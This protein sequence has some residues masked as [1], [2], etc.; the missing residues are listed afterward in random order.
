M[1]N[2]IYHPQKRIFYSVFSMEGQQV[3]NN[4]LL[5]GGSNKQ[6]LLKNADVYAPKAYFQG[7]NE[8]ETKK[9]LKRIKEGT[10]TSHKDPNAYRDFETDFRNGERIKTKPSRYT[11]QWKKY[12]PNATSLEDKAKLTGVP[13][14]IVEKVYN[15]G[16]AAWRT[17]HRPGANVQQ[18]GYA[19]VHS[20]LVKG[21]TFYTTDNKLA[22]LAIKQ[23]KKAKDW[24]DWV[25]GL[26]DSKKNREKNKWCERACQKTKCK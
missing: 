1:Y 25:D 4:Y 7:L 12:F 6:K 3:L 5:L 21:K 14:D 16:M 11:N 18:W 26:C 17:G 22:K 15:K 2:W 13:L 20:F 10:E 23:S 9:R 24:F 8:K 19:R